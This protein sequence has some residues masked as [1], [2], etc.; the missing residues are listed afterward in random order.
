[1]RYIH[2][3]PGASDLNTPRLVITLSKSMTDFISRIILYKENNMKYLDFVL[4][5]DKNNHPC[6]PINNGKARYLL[7][8]NKAKIINH[9]PTVIKRLD[10]YKADNEIRDIFELKIDSG[11]LNIGFSV[12]DNQHEYLAGQVELL[13]K[14]RDRIYTRSTL[15]RS[16]RSRLRYRK[17]KNIDYKI[18]N[19]P[20]YKNGNE[21]GWFAPS[22][23]HKMESHVRLVKKI[24][25]WIP[26]DK[27]ILEVAKFDIQKLKADAEGKNIS[28]KD[29]QN[30]EMKGYEN[31]SA[32]VRARDEYTCQI[33]KD[34]KGKNALPGK[35]QVHHIVP[36][37]NGG[38]DIPSN[39]ICL[40]PEHHQ[41]VHN[42]HNNNK[43]FKELQERKIPTFYKDSTYMN[44]VRWR[45][46]GRLQELCETE[47][48]YGYETKIN[49]KKASLEKYHYTDAVC[50]KNFKDTTLAKTIY[51]VEQKRC[52]DRCM[53]TFTDAKYIDSRDGKKKNGNQLAYIRLSNRPSARVTQKEYIDNQRIYREKKISPGKRTF[54]KHS[55][56]LKSGDLIY[57]NAGGHKGILAE[58]VTS[59]IVKSGGYKI[60]FTYEGQSV[61]NPSITLKPFEYEQLRENKCEKIKIVRT[62]RGMI[63]RSID[64]LEYESLHCDQYDKKQKAA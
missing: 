7:K 53:E 57:I 43:L 17:N 8:N 29:Y 10:D 14:M 13:T 21:E 46:F 54:V 36:R 47:I 52:N 35:I 41:K 63:W 51:I 4:M 60:L 44:I 34:K 56:C 32:Y 59:Q 15:R 62:R 16:R 26:V 50:I 22:I 6:C 37:E 61:D 31:A 25:S 19:N 11:Y 24:M 18:T 1:M 23:E 45:L 20:T 58:Y 30:G 49:R 5:V 2:I 48:A 64:R 40:C 42:N 38:S 33:C 12:S 55:Y 39:L 27:I 28:G 3:K 9:E